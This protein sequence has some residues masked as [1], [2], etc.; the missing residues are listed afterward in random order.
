MLIVIGWRATRR[1]FPFALTLPLIELFGIGDEVYDRRFVDPVVA[2]R[3]HDT[4]WGSITSST[5]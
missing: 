3:G 5:V 2:L 4:S 1:L